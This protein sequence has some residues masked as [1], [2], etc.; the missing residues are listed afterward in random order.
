M[1]YNSKTIEARLQNLECAIK[2]YEAYVIVKTADGEE[3]E[4][5][6]AEYVDNWQTMDFQRVG[7]N[8]NIKALDAVLSVGLQAAYMMGDNQDETADNTTA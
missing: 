8:F 2:P 7:K 3:R 5:S 1:Q 6:V 4:V